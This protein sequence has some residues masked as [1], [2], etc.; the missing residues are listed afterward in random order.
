M[1]NNTY[2]TT[3]TRWSHTGISAVLPLAGCGDAGVG[4]SRFVEVSFK[5]FEFAASMVIVWMQ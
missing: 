3:K 4:F 1:Q 5:G 2:T